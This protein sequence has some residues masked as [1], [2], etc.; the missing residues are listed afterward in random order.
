[1]ESV[2][3]QSS[4]A[5]E[6]IIIDG[7]STD[8]SL[9]TIRKFVNIPPATYT[10][11]AFPV[12]YWVSEPDAG[13]YNAM[14]KGISQARGKYCLFINSSDFLADKNVIQDI[15]ESI[16]NADIIC[17]RCAITQNGNVVHITNPPEKITFGTLY[18]GGGLSH[19]ATLIKK[20]LF[21]DLGMYDEGY[22]YN[23]DIEF[24]YRSIVLNAATTQKIKTLISYYNL[25][26]LSSSHNN[27]KEFVDEHKK[28]LS[29]PFFESIIPDYEAWKVKQEEMKVSYWIKSKSFLYN[30]LLL[31]YKI[32]QYFKGK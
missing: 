19:Q 6:H 12:T 5:F 28:I 9:N 15:F 10:P 32:A 22:K 21:K 7:N 2:V 25:E 13:I 16:T 24:W 31:L 14:N 1:M 3:N 27:S 26:G 4:Q 30:P 29:H 20:E 23:G 17:G 8:G 18:S 11:E